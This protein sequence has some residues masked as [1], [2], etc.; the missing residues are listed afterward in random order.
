MKKIVKFLVIIALIMIISVIIIKKDDE[1]IVC[2]D[3]G[4]GG[5]DVGAVN[6]NRYEKNDNL[7]IAQLVEK[8]LQ[9]QGI[10]TIMT[11][12][13]DIEVSLRERCKIA[14]RKKA[15]FFVSIHRNS[16]KQGNGIEIW[17][18]SKKAQKD[19][20]LAT[21]ILKQIQGTE[22]QSDRGI[23]TGTAKGERTN[24]YVLNN[25]K[26]PSCLIELGFITEEK[27][28]ELFDKNIEEYAKAIAE[29]ILEQISQ[30]QN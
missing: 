27:D 26:M 22:I 16:G 30:K 11:R 14:N 17:I 20:D 25:T 5:T 1:I 13:S 15:D 12:N 23:K 21:S 3:P 4:H 29:G 28:N 7:K 10:T 18:N 24:Y 2:I 8:Y 6:E 19:F 9:N